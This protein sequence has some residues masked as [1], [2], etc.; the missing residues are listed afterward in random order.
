MTLEG[1]FSKRLV[2]W[3]SRLF[4]R[5]NSW[6]VRLLRLRF[7]PLGNQEVPE[8]GSVVKCRRSPLMRW[9]RFFET[10]SL[11]DT[12]RSCYFEPGSWLRSTKDPSPSKFG[13]YGFIKGAETLCQLVVARMCWNYAEIARKRVFV[14][15]AITRGKI[16]TNYAEYYTRNNSIFI[17]VRYPQL[18]G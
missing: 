7:M 10:G 3:F 18:V 9:R 15:I 12:L 6:S 17:K 13:K 14:E 1:H 5:S 11:D 8:A 2:L 16:G 4:L